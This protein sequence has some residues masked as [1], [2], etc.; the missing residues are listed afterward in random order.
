M[1]DKEDHMGKYSYI[2]ADKVVTIRNVK[3]DPAGVWM[4]ATVVSRTILL[5]RIAHYREQ[6][7]IHAQGVLP[8]LAL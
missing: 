1:S 7:M 8:L 4:H 2:P 6:T 5:R 3:E